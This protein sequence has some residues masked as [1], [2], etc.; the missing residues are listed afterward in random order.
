MRW[1]HTLQESVTMIAVI[2]LCVMIV[3]ALNDTAPVAIQHGAWLA[4][5]RS[6]RPGET[7]IVYREYTVLRQ[8]TGSTNRSII[9]GNIVFPLPSSEI[10]EIT[11]GTKTRGFAIQVPLGV[12]DGA[13][14]YVVTT[15]Y[16]V[17]PLRT[18]IT[19]RPVVSFRV[20]RETQ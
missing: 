6:Y 16:H 20:A 13:C 4:E 3:L 15:H 19:Q 2:V 1:L 10:F 7:L 8:V 18:Q 17:N 9:C 5:D 14:D 12:P 11:L